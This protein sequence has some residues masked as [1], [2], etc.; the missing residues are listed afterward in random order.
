LV[1]LEGTWV[2]VS[3][4]VFGDAGELPM[5]FVAMTLKTYGVPMLRPLMVHDSVLEVQD[6]PGDPVTL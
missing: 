2:S 4:L 6:P 5:L 3:A 1:G